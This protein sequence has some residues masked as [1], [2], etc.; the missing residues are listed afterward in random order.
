MGTAMP[1]RTRDCR[2]YAVRLFGGKAR[3]KE[4]RELLQDLVSA[5]VVLAVCSYNDASVIRPLLQELSLIELFSPD[6]ILGAEM[7]DLARAQ[8][9]EW[10]KGDVIR[11]LIV[12]SMLPSA[13]S[14][15]VL[16]AELAPTPMQE[17]V[18][19]PS[20]GTIDASTDG[21][22]TLLFV[23]DM[24][25]NCVDV[26][27]ACPGCATLLV[28]SEP[29][30][31]RAAQF[32]AI[33]A[34]AGAP[35]ANVDAAA[36]PSITPAADPADDDAALA[37]FRRAYYAAFQACRRFYAAKAAETRML[38]EGA[39]VARP[40]IEGL[41]DVEQ[42]VVAACSAVTLDLRALLEATVATNGAD[43]EESAED[44]LEAVRA[45]RGIGYAMHPLP[46][47]VG[48]D[49]Q[50][51]ASQFESNMV[52]LKGSPL[53]AESMAALAR[54]VSATSMTDMLSPGGVRPAQWSDADTKLLS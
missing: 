22:N 15:G 7:C 37:S 24:P 18:F 2:Q 40:H 43:A 38:L 19:V 31:L 28:P 44:R 8:G 23:D 30:G 9:H 53:S 47:T 27:R 5:G 16:L 35:R 13:E 52:V 32:S 12:P 25:A 50:F 11:E 46:H 33:R 1:C 14:T 54:L 3:L 39:L 34:W 10:D 21:S 6:H 51:S 20:L 29:G 4:L 42:R 36:P 49:V 26:H 48:G 41:F 17:P 45:L